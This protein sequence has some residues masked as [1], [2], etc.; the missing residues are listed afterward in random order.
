MIAYSL[1]LDLLGLHENSVVLSCA[2]LKFDIEK[3]YSFSELLDNC[4]FIK[5]NLKEQIEK[6]K[7]E[8]SKETYQ[9]WKTTPQSIQESVFIPGKNDL[10]L[11]E[12]LSKIAEYIDEKCPCVFVRGFIDPMIFNSLYYCIGKKSPI[13]PNQWREVNTAI[14]TLKDGN[15]LNVNCKNYS[16]ENVCKDVLQLLG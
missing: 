16:K 14:H 13:F 4:L 5:F 9:Y 15:I 6:Y 8:F 10:T 1:D 2:V 11:E 3:T 12:G 7:R